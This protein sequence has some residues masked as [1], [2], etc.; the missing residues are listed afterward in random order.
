MGSDLRGDTANGSAVHTAEFIVS[1]ARLTE[2]YECA[3]LLRRTRVRAEE[4]VD[5]ARALVAE[6][7]QH[8]DAERALLLEDQLEQ[9]HARYRQVL[10]AYLV[11]CRRINEERQDI[12]RVQLER[13]RMTGLSG[14][15]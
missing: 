4:I 1:S 14:V 11:L 12:L 15:A 8:G 7:R 9:A 5:E 2:L 10:K 3:V 6:A 13:D